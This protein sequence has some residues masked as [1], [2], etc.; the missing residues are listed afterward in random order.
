[1]L[2][3]LTK[4]RIKPKPIW[5]FGLGVQR[6]EVALSCGKVFVW[7]NI[8]FFLI[9]TLNLSEYNFNLSTTVISTPQI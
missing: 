1:M 5:H 3:K 4:Y 6:N 8:Q 9:F 2:L 7:S